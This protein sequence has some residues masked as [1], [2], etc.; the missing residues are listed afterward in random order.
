MAL[1]ENLVTRSIIIYP[2]L[3]AWQAERGETEGRKERE[4]VVAA[5]FIFEGEI[6]LALLPIT[7]TPPAG[8]DKAYELP[9][10]EVKRIARGAATRLWIILSEANIERVAQSWYL[11]PDCKIGEIS[12]ATWR[13]FEKAFTDAVPAMVRL[14]RYE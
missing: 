6:Y 8:D 5:R 3:W 2:Y 12:K 4:T 9:A 13:D 11:A 1:H 10:L 14:S 7:A